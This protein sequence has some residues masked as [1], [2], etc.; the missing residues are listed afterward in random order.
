MGPETDRETITYI[1]DRHEVNTNARDALCWS[2]DHKRINK[3]ICRKREEKKGGE[4]ERRE[5]KR[6][7]DKPVAAWSSQIGRHSPL[8]QAWI[9]SASTAGYTSHLGVRKTAD[10]RA[11]GPDAV[12][13]MGAAG[14]GAEHNYRGCVK[15]IRT[16][17]PL[18]LSFSLCV[19]LYVSTRTW[20]ATTEICR[21]VLLTRRAVCWSGI[22]PTASG[23]SLSF[24]FLV[25][26]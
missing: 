19:S 20:L 4:N 8:T 18:L 13:G 9:G 26:H 12:V 25:S 16:S 21:C 5:R 10:A 6:R 22:P 24:P 11:M 7:E 1:V 14:T 3:K 15:S 17:L 23:D 2:K